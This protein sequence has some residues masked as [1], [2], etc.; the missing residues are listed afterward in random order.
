MPPAK[1]VKS[2]ADSNSRANAGPAG[3]PTAEDLE[4]ESEFAALAR[5]HWLKTP[6]QA[7]KAKSKA[8]VK[9]KNNVLKREI[10]D[11]LEKE[12][13]PL[14]SL[15]VLESLQTLERLVGILLYVCVISSLTPSQLP[16]ARLRRGLVQLPCP[17]DCSDR[18]CQAEGT[19]R[20]LGCVCR[21]V[22]PRLCS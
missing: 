9:V 21:H 11:T 8:K 16:V 7:S 2:S 12:N 18:Q 5:Q 1:R 22:P 13:F 6:K 3:R 14:K 10:W 17:L 15:L 20:H 19:L 4:G